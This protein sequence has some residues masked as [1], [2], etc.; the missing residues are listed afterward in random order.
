LIVNAL[1]VVGLSNVPV[2]K[3]GESFSEVRF[4]AVEIADEGVDEFGVTVG[5]FLE[6]SE[7]H[8]EGGPVLFPHFLNQKD[9]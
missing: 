3:S 6:V 7:T 9:I 2:D 8:M 4:V 1:G 5:E